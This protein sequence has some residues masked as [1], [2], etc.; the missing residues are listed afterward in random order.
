MMDEDV[1]AMN[2]A[3][4]AAAAAASAEPQTDSNLHDCEICSKI[5]AGTI[6]FCTN[7]FQKHHWCLL[8]NNTNWVT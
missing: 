5:V 1:A 2:E 6:T 3:L 8:L 7:I 4:A